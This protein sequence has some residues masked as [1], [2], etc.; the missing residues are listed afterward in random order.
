MVHAEAVRIGVVAPLRQVA[1]FGVAA[2]VQPVAAHRAAVVLQLAEARQLL[3]GLADDLGRILG[4]LDVRERAAVDLLENF[5]EVGIDRVGVRPGDVEHR[6]RQRAALLAVE[7]ADGEE[8]ARENLLVGP[9]LARWIDRLPLPLQ[10]ARRVGE[11]AVLLGEARAG[12]LED[13]GLDLRRRNSAELLRL[14]VVPEGGG[15]DRVVLA[16]HHPLELGERVD[17]LRAVGPDADR[18]HA[19]GDETLRPGLRAAGDVPFVAPVHVV[20]DEHPRVVA[21]GLRQPLVAE[22]VL[23]GGRFPVR[24]LE[25]RGHELG[26]V[27]P[28]VHRR[29]RLLVQRRGRHFLEVGLQIGQLGRRCPAPVAAWPRRG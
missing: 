16:D 18:V 5:A 17:H 2:G 23:L 7:I 1:G 26:I 4:V 20:E 22:L 12:E 15:L 24:R 6:L 9:G 3:A 11:G 25:Q 13:F 8:D 21:V 27:L 10:P 29:P 14:L 28:V 19:E